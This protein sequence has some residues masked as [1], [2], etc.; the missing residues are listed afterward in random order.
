MP[1]KPFTAQQ[2]KKQLQEKR[3]K[4]KNKEEHYDWGSYAKHEEP[5]QEVAEQTFDKQNVTSMVTDENSTLRT[6]FEKEPRSVIEERIKQARNPIP[7]F[8]TSE[9]LEQ[10]PDHIYKALD[11]PLRPQWHYGMKRQELEQQEEKYFDNYLHQ[12]YKDHPRESLNYFEHNLNVWRQLWRTLEISDI[13]LLVADVRHPLFHFPQSLYKHVTE[14]LQKPLILLLNKCD[15]VPI[16]FQEMW[17]QWF[18]E[19]YPKLL[20]VTFSSYDSPNDTV[21]EQEKKQ[22]LQKKKQVDTKLV[23]KIW[24]ACSQVPM[25]EEKKQYWKELIEH[26]TIQDDDNDNKRKFVTVGLVGHP[27]TGKSCVLNGLVG[28]TV[29]SASYTPGHTKHFQTFFASKHV[30]LCDSP[31]LVFPAIDMPRPL[32]V[33][34]GLFP[35]AQAR[36]PYSAIRY[37]VDRVPIERIYKLYTLPEGSTEWSAW[38]LCEAYAIKRKYF[39]PKRARPDVYRGANEILRDVL[40]GR[41]LLCFTPPSDAGEQ[42]VLT[43]EQVMMD[44][45]SVQLLQQEDESAE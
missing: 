37:L 6:I 36:E 43:S 18:K 14:Q 7:R 31:G 17:V 28:K 24:Q 42:R 5:K 20:I 15:L 40:Y 10:T 1:G 23:Y 39:T 45:K 22:Q 25:S 12:I 30:R 33:L 26:E 44:K 34:C 19:H 11:M 21:I 13:L 9:T 3:I 8:N 41:V 32:Q 38:S 29:V 27:N 35:I 2:K 16:S 4:K